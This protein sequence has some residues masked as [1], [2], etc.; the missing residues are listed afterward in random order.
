MKGDLGKE[1][2]KLVAPGKCCKALSLDHEIYEGKLIMLYISI[3]LREF[4]GW[5]C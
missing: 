5:I 1:P 2:M 3:S 4:L